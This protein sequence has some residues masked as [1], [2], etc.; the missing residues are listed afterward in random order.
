MHIS[1]FSE[2]RR[3]EK[4]LVEKRTQEL[5]IQLDLIQKEIE[6]IAKET[7]KLSQELAIAAQ[8]SIDSKTSTFEFFFLNHLLGTIQ[9][10]RTQIHEASTWLHFYNTRKAKKSN[11]WG[12]N[13]KKY[14]AKYLLSGEHYAQRSA[15]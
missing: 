3:E 10:F 8:I 13:Y 11:V 12:Q 5:R 7:P 9:D 4:L 1:N 15:A 2:L 6:K 14:G